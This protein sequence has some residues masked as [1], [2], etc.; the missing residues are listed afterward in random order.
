MNNEN[1]IELNN[2]V[3]SSIKLACEDNGIS[4]TSV[5]EY[6]RK[7]HC[8]TEEALVAVYAKSLKPSEK[9]MAF[10]EYFDNVAQASRRFEVSGDTVRA[11]MRDLGMNIEEA[12]EETRKRER[13]TKRCIQN[14][15]NPYAARNF[16]RVS[17]CTQEEAIESLKLAASSK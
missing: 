7:N 13:F 17:K 15:I 10:G 6:R 12:I 11:C 9:I 3:Y 16:I 5:Y 14:G 4:V 2:K 1:S 8:T